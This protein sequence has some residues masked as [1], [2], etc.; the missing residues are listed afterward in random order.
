MKSAD[1]PPVKEVTVSEISIPL[2]KIESLNELEPDKSK[3][4][5]QWSHAVA[6]RR[7]SSHIRQIKSQPIPVIRIPYEPKY[8]D[9]ECGFNTTRLMGVQQMEGKCKFKKE[10]P[11]KKRHK[12]TITEDSH[13]SSLS[14]L[15]QV[16]LETEHFTRHL[17]SKGKE[18]SAKKTVNTIILIFKEKKVDP[19]TTKWK[20]EHVM[21][22][23][24]NHIPLAN[25]NQL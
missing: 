18:K 15:I 25:K 13:T 2:A 8:N 1:R 4:G 24:K 3:S 19:F 17:N 9:Y 5:T 7:K 21:V 12:I 20:E 16:N 6:G 11:D 14:S 10:K 23:A 22:R